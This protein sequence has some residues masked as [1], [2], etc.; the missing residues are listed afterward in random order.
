[1]Y[2]PS[3]TFVGMDVHKKT[4]R[5]ALLVPGHREPVEWQEANETAAVR[6]LGRR[7][8]RES[9]GDLLACYEAGPTGYALQRQLRAA[10]V[11]CR[12]IAPSLTP[13]KPGERIKTDRRDARKLAELLRADLLTEVHPPSESE[14][15]LR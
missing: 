4:I 15:A 13:R 7:L 10:G 11:P 2:D 6:R 12:V 1:M 8:V 3:T 5:V 14:E 9:G